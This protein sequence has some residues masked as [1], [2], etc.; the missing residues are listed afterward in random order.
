MK[1]FM[2]S[3]LDLSY[4]K[5]RTKDEII[6]HWLDELNCGCFGLPHLKNNSLETCW[7]NFLKEQSPPVQKGPIQFLNLVCARESLFVP[8]IP[9]CPA[10]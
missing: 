8:D 9:S 5:C 4:R 10:L 6:S 7:N 3:V 1:M 2:Y